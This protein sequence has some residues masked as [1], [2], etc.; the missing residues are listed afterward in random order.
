MLLKTGFVNVKC[1][2]IRI[3]SVLASCLCLGLM[4]A[5]MVISFKLFVLIARPRNVCLK[6]QMLKYIFLGTCHCVLRILLC[7][8]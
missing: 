1:F 4:A 7:T 3:K 6:S 8:V 2:N 5:S